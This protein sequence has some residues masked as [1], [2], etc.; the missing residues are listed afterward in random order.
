MPDYDNKIKELED[1]IAG[2]KY[3]KKTQ[4]AIGLYKAQIAKLKE[5]QELRGS[6]GGKGDGYSVRKTGDGTVIL[7]GFPSVGKSTLLNDLTNA[8]SEVAAYAFTTLTVIP[9]IMSYNNAKIQILDVPGIVRG[10]ASGK[11]RG[12][13]VLAVMRNADL[14]LMI[15]DVAAPEQLDFLKKEVY[16]VG[17]RL[18]EK[19]PDVKLVRTTKDGIRIGTTVKLT[20]ITREIIVDVLK[21]F[22]INNADVVLRENITVDQF[23]DCIQS[24][25][26]YMPSV[27]C[28]NKIDLADPRTVESVM[29]MT[30]ADM[31]ISAEK[32][33]GIEKLKEITF[34]KLDLVRIWMKEPGKEADM[35]IPLIMK[36]NSTIG[37]VCN[38]LH[39]DFV[40]KFKFAR[41]WGP[42]AKFDGQKLMLNHVLV[43]NDVLE[44]HL[45]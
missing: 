32:K 14:V 24:N 19:K 6:K 18:D 27:V 17:I 10:A 36:R 39:R 11:G 3:N 35:K 12:R 30:R 38:R 8:Q 42:S 44:L 20:K 29:K 28:V 41:V 1:T 34:T 43:D 15:V 37:D 9:G 7:L 22:K 13:E 40:T 4:H 5:K 33:Q 2:V 45:T 16:D 25:K 26:V 31:A 23:I 21:E